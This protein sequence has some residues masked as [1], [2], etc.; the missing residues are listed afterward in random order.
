M[1]DIESFKL[2]MNR[3]CAFAIDLFIVLILSSMVSNV[4]KANPYM[5]DYED[6]YKA[7]TEANSDI[8]KKK[9][10]SSLED[11]EV[12]VKPLYNLQKVQTYEYLWFIAF[13]I[14]YFVIFQ[15][16]NDGQT[17]GKKISK[18]KV[19][20]AKDENKRPNIFQFLLHTIFCGSSFYN[21]F[22][23][24]VLLNVIAL[25]TL[26]IL[27]YFLAYTVIVMLGFGLELASYIVFFTNKENKGLNDMI[28]GVKTINL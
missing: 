4:Y 7:F 24:M 1:Q 5:Y 3:I 17:L 27:N 13:L 6:T 12:M 9:E 21:G 23:L 22:H 14:F 2:K 28:S 15:Y 16:L 20:S 8:S 26:N 10:I 25:L 11:L 18:I 19:V